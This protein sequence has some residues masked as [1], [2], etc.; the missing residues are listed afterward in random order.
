MTSTP[1]VR[2]AALDDTQ[3]ISAL[4]RAR[5][6]VW[7]RMDAAGRVQDVPY[8]SLTIYE[9]WLHGGPWMSIETAVLHLSHMMR[10]AGIPVVAE[11]DGQ[12]VAYA[13]AYHGLEPEPI[14]DHLHVAVLV[15]GTNTSAASADAIF[16]HYLEQARASGCARLTADLLPNDDDSQSLYKRHGLQSILRVKRYNLPAK[17]GQGFYKVSDHLGANPAQ[18]ADWH[19][20]VGRLGSARQQWETLW[21][22]TFYALAE[23]RARRTH[24][25]Q[26]SASGQEALVYC[27]QNMYNPRAAELSVWSPKLLTSQVLTALRDWS[28]REGYRTLVMTVTD[29]TAKILSAEADPDGYY[30]D[31]YALNV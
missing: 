31:V 11:L 5:I 13:E 7:Q 20:T 28:H 23:I 3:A 16:S 8:D 26:F 25:L 12:I 15:L 29:D 14:G 22:R 10:G 6:P 21:P 4:F 17:S 30:Q 24:R 27:Q 2:P 18:I 9:R 19:M 1:L